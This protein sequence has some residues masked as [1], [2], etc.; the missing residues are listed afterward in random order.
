MKW[1]EKD[2]LERIMVYPDRP[3]L[4]SLPQMEAAALQVLLVID[5]NK[6]LLGIVTDGDIRRALLNDTDLK[7]KIQNVMHPSPKV[8]PLN[9]TIKRAI[10]F[11]KDFSLKHVP[12]VDDEGKLQDLII[13]SDCFK[14][15]RKKH[16]EKVIIMAG[17]RGT[18]LDP[19][20]KILPKPM[21]P[22]GDKPIIETI[23]DNLYQQGFSEFIITLGYKAEIIKMYF[24]ESSARPYKVS[25]S[26]ETKPLG[27]AGAI[28]LLQSQIDT[29]ALITNCDVI[30]ELDYSELLEHHRKEKNLMTM[31][32]T[33]KNFTIPYGVVRTEG[34]DLDM[35]EEKPSF[36]FMINT[37]LYI[38]EP[39][40]IEFIQED[41]YIHMTDLM[42][43][44]K[45][46]Q[47]KVGVYPHHGKWFDVGQWEDYRNTIRQFGVVE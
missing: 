44:I 15:E 46:H 37:G 10:K 30:L 42:I 31:V 3:L 27:T 8:L 9:S 4:D 16:Q 43:R 5:D 47:G 19:F 28:K 41:E 18:R 17:G 26:Y 36:H 35:I 40:V 38:I 21:I 29:T 45:A 11:M 6:K 33:V 24:V 20:T 34:Q 13:W 7:I 1:R 39:E 14:K 22:I 12:L 2:E 25:F 32:S 23:M